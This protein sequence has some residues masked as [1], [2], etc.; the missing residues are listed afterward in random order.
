MSDTVY[1]MPF[2]HIVQEVICIN[3]NK[4]FINVRPTAVW[5]KECECP[6][7][8]QAGFLIATG[9]DLPD[10]FTGEYE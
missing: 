8:N 5:L 7:C 1:E 9:Q 6:K 2:P 3:C 10:D 4:R